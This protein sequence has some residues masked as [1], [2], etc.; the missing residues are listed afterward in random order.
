[1]P[2]PPKQQRYEQ[3][4]KEQGLCAVHGCRNSRLETSCWCEEHRR[5]E[6]TRGINSYRKAK[7]FV[8]QMYGGS[9]RVCSETRI[10]CLELD[11]VNND[12]YIHR[13]EMG[14]KIPYAWIKR[15]GY[16]D[17][18]QLLCASCH[19]LKHYR[20]P[21]TLLALSITRPACLV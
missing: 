7:E 4:R 13:K 21:E 16:C 9:C 17:K 20:D 18:F 1:M 10:G 3:K 2:K 6:I 12:G 5:K 11:H 14:D 8:I 19:R 15:N